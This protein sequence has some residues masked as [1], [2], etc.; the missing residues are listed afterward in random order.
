VAACI[1]VSPFGV[2]QNSFPVGTHFVGEHVRFGSLSDEHKARIVDYLDGRGDERLSRF[3]RQKPAFV[4]S[5]ND[6]STLRSVS[7]IADKTDYAFQLHRYCLEVFSATPAPMAA[8]HYDGQTITHHVYD[9]RDAMFRPDEE[10]ALANGI[11]DNHLAYLEF[12][13]TN[14]HL[15]PL[16][17][18][19]VTRLCR[20]LRETATNDGIID[21]A[22]GLEALIVTQN[23]I[24]FQ[25]AL[26]HALIGSDDMVERQEISLLL[27][28][29]YDARSLIVH[30]GSPSRSD[31]N[32]IADV[33]SSWQRLQQIARSSLTYYIL[34]CSQQPPGGWKDHLVSLA[35]GGQR[36][37]PEAAA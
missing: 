35:L 24:K 7:D 2:P 27:K 30:G 14:A 28:T 4:V 13:Y 8:F 5:H 10:A 17:R 6:L 15:A 33:R 22:I 9:T 12:I 36:V 3:V 1:I 31:L 19:S 25:F 20:A 34:Y 26:F 23:E 32:K 18:L 16:A 29:L 37:Q 11:W 21:L